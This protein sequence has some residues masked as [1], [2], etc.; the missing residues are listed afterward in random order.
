MSLQFP[1]VFLLVLL[2]IITGNKLRGTEPK[3]ELPEPQA[4]N[5]ETEE[6]GFAFFPATKKERIEAQNAPTDPTVEEAKSL[7]QPWQPFVP[8]GIDLGATSMLTGDS[9]MVTPIIDRFRKF[10]HKGN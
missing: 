8:H 4:A 1:L 6:K 10:E 3:E 9:F 5:G 7:D 2:T